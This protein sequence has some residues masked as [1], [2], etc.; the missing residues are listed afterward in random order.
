[1]N[2]NPEPYDLLGGVGT[3]AEALGNFL[4]LVLLVAIVTSLAVQGVAGPRFVLKQMLRGL[5]DVVRISPRRTWALASLTIKEAIRRKALLIF[6]VFAVLFMF[7][8]WFLDDP[9]ARGDMQVKVYVSFVLTS[10]TWL[11][12]PVILLLSCWGIPEDIKARSLH[13]VVTKPVRRTEVVIGRILGFTTVATGILVLMSAVG[14]I[15]VKRQL[16]TNVDLTCRV[17]IYAAYDPAVDAVEEGT[18]VDQET[19][20]N[21]GFYFIDQ[22]G[23]AKATGINTGDIVEFWSYIQGATNARAV[24]QFKDFGPQYLNEKGQLKLETR[25][26][27]FRSHKGRIKTK[28]LC[29][30][31]FTDKSTGKPVAL[32]A[33][34][35]DEFTNNIFVLDREINYYDTESG[36]SKTVDLIDDLVDDGTLRIV[37]QALDTGQYLG[38]AKSSLFIRLPDQSFAVGYSKAVA[39]IWLMLSLIVMLGVTASCFVKGPVATFLTLSLLIMGQGFRDFMLRL[40]SDQVLGGGPAEAWYRILKHM[41]PMQE[42]PNTVGSQIIGAIDSFLLNILWIAQH[43]VPN[44]ESFKLSN[45]VANGFDVPWAAGML[46]SVAMTCAYVIPCLLIGYYSLS[47]RELEAK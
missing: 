14:Y 24:W 44:F 30:L 34:E 23:N 10:I 4:G 9:D 37:A 13:T 12:V 21:A 5:I 46:P 15:W 22:N 27:S 42:M 11:T 40:T 6:V 39:G 41:N 20:K 3:W 33:F 18:V 7:A 32:P 17:P 16:P 25:F 31:N 35:V 1:M 19:L 36:E 2:F 47:L 29:Q 43:I 38:M 28:L 45:Y 26:L 8:G